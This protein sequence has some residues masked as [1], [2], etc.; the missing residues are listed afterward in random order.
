[1]VEIASYQETTQTNT[2]MIVRS[3]RVR[4]P[5]GG[6]RVPGRRDTPEVVNP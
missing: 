4:K 2:Q 5:G 1:M 3:L 6:E